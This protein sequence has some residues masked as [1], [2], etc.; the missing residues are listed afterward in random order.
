[1]EALPVTEL[2][3][4]L[5]LSSFYVLG[6]HRKGSRVAR[7][8]PEDEF[9]DVMSDDEMFSDCEQ[10]AEKSGSQ[11]QAG[12]S[13]KRGSDQ[14]KNSLV[15]V[16][17]ELFIDKLVYLFQHQLSDGERRTFATSGDCLAMIESSMT[18]VSNWYEHRGSGRSPSSAGSHDLRIFVSM[19]SLQEAI[20]G[21]NPAVLD[22]DLAFFVG[23]YRILSMPEAT[24][25]HSPWVGQ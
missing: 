21:M 20:S 14:R 11:Q 15:A 25:T 6:T 2:I 24:L 7:N 13:A 1:M 10:G 5:A 18:F 23:Y 9:D 12:V 4:R 16:A 17:A 8:S 22:A 3:T 19:C